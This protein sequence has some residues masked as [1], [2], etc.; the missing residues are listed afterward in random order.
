MHDGGDLFRQLGLRGGDFGLRGLREHGG[1]AA[2][3]AQGR[4]EGAYLGHL[5]SGCRCRLCGTGCHAIVV[6]L[7]HDLARFH[8]VAFAHQHVRDACGHPCRHHDLIAFN[9]AIDL[10][11]A[12]V[13]VG[14]S[15]QENTGGQGGHG[16]QA[17][18][19]HPATCAC[20]CH[21]VCLPLFA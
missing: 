7:E 10:D 17:C 2:Q 14:L 18:P 9:A 1:F 4:F 20:P 8:H 15:G 16:H 3:Q 21:L 5:G 6:Q 11:Q 13:R 12:T 19:H